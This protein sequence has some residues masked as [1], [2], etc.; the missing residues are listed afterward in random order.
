MTPYVLDTDI[1]T[2]YRRGHEIVTRRVEAV[3][4]DQIAISVI[5][6]EE[7]L[8]GWYAVVRQARTEEKLTRAYA[9]L[10]EVTEALRRIRDLPFPAAAVGRYLDLRKQLPRL[11][12]LDLAIAAIVLDV[13]GTLV[14]RNQ[15]DFSQVPQL[16]L[17]DW[18][19]P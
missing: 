17:E 10:F 11:G 13:Q 2:L 9:G 5:T 16:R 3:P 7:Q 4:A 12:K 6:I 8:S 18:S 1:F 14:T 19:K 15:S